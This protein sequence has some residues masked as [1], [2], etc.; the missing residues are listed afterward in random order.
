MQKA[1]LR[2]LKRVRVNNPVKFYLHSSCCKRVEQSIRYSGLV[3]ICS[4]YN[5]I[6]KCVYLIKLPV[7][8]DSTSANKCFC[9]VLFSTDEFEQRTTEA[10]ST[11][12]TFVWQF[13]RVNR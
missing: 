9:F 3:H 12:T 11:R 2:P 8:K 1:W 7:R 4:H 13:A 6:A 10:T 5:L